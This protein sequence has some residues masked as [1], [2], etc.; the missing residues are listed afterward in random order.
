MSHKA[1]S[2]SGDQPRYDGMDPEGLIDSN[3]EEVCENFDDMA[4][5][6]L[7]VPHLIL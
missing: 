2:P 1:N 4:L 7:L 3:W 5:R 6:L